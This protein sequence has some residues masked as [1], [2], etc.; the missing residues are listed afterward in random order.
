VGATEEAKEVKN[1]K[2]SSLLF[3]RGVWEFR[4]LG[5]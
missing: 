3:F 5:I 1:E 4:S 2:R